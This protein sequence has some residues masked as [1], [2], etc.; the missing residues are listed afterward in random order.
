MKECSYCHIEKPLDKFSKMTASK[1]GLQSRCKEC[2]NELRRQDRRT[3]RNFIQAIKNSGCFHCGT[4]APVEMLDFH[5]IDPSNKKLTVSE[6]VGRGVNFNALKEE[7]DK[8]IILCKPCHRE[9]HS[10]N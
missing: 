8:C 5:H 7:L 2:V 10:G 9:V 4:H 3:R 6:A 1:D